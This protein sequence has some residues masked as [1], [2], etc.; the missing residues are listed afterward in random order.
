MDFYYP[1]EHLDDPIGT[2]KKYDHE[3][4]SQMLEDLE[5]FSNIEDT[6]IDNKD[7]LSTKIV[8]SVQNDEKIINIIVAESLRN[9]V[10]NNV[11]DIVNLCLKYTDHK[12]IP[13]VITNTFTHRE[14]CLKKVRARVV[15]TSRKFPGFF[16]FSGYK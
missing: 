3:N 8:S 6:N 14:K 16:K 12:H 1:G 10:F 15:A 9:F 7:V 11:G 5:E 4:L 2:G 13:S